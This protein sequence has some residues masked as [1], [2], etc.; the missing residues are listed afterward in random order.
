M[1]TI[2]VGKAGKQLS[3]EPI[4]VPI[5]KA[6][7]IL[8]KLIRNREAAILTR[9]GDDVAILLPMPADAAHREYQIVAD[10]KDG[11]EMWSIVPVMPKRESG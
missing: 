6:T 5:G 4:R 3:A 9:L 1:K 10:I 8:S 7:K 2:P 11:C